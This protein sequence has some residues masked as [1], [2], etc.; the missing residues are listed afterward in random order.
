M[1]SS[2]C[3]QMTAFL[4]PL[5]MLGRSPALLA[6]CMVPTPPL[7]LSHP[8]A[9]QA[10]VVTSQLLRENALR[11]D[12]LATMQVERVWQGT[13]SEIVTLLRIGNEIEAP[14]LRI[15]EHW[16]VTPLAVSEP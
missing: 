8:L 10:Q 6:E 12:V 14:D 7:L 13:V 11:P 2:C 1:H 5:V 16:I 3:R 4:T 15:G 9:F